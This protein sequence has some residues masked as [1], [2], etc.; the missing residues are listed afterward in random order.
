VSITGAIVTPNV[1]GGFQAAGINTGLLIRDCIGYNPA[2]QSAIT[3]GASPFTYTAG[4]ASETIYIRG[5][6]VSDIKLGSTT[7]AAASPAQL[8]IAPNQ[9]VTVTYTVAPTMVKDI[10]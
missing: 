10:Q 4:P 7:V 1:L 3:V 5:G 6:T 8:S 9:A 2:G